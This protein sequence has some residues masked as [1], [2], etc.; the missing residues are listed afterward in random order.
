MGEP[1]EPDESAP[2]PHEESMGSAE[3]HDPPK[4]FSWKN[5]HNNFVVF[6]AVHAV[7]EVH[8]VQ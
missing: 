4:K 1:H 7:H 5:I 3:P 2:E 8:A 6:Y